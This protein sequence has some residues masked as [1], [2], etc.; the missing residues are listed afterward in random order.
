MSPLVRIAN[1][2]DRPHCEQLEQQAQDST[3]GARG[4]AAFFAE[5]P[6]SFITDDSN[7]FTLVAEVDEVVIG[8]ATV[9]ITS[10]A[11]TN[12]A[13]VVRVFVTARARRVGV[14]DALI[15]AAK[16]HARDAHCVRIDALSLPGDRDT[17][18]LYE[19]NGLTARL[20]VATSTL[21]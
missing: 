1:T 7:G 16:Q 18:N 20:I 15:N 4:A 2:A 6:I 9:R 21:D 5:Q 13:T 17:K 8:L 10:V 14:G 12:I 3:A 11:G 19:R